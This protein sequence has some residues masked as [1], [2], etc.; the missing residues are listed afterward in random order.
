LSVARGGLFAVCS[1]SGGG[2]TTI[3]REVIRGL[4]ARGQSAH[5]SIS[6]TTRAPRA[7]EVHGVDYYFVDRGSFEA[8]VARGEFLE[9]AEY[10]GNLYGTSRGEVEVHLESGRDVFLDIDV[11]GA[12]Q[13]KA[14]L[15]EVIRVFVLPPSLEVLK[16]RLEARGKDAPEVIARR[17]RHAFK[18]MRQCE[19]FDYA[20][21]NDRLEEAVAALSCIEATARLRASRQASRVQR[22]LEEFRS[23]VEEE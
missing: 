15:P 14:A 12:D 22:I 21:I 6:H 2:K 18:E 16:R 1:P 3:I 8:M 20:I 9:H 4:E 7:G 5:F 17:I 13:V 10:V 23:T 19:Q 11:Q